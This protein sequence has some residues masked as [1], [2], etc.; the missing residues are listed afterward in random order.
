MAER[1]VLKSVV[2]VRLTADELEALRRAADGKPLS[3]Y[4]R[5]VVLSRAKEIGRSAGQWRLSLAA[6]SRAMGEQLRFDAGGLSP[7][8][9]GS[10]GATTGIGQVG[11]APASGG[12]QYRYPA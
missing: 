11:S 6:Q 1:D 12:L 4:L 5:D 10:T 8:W 2:S 7:Q 3:N 9:S